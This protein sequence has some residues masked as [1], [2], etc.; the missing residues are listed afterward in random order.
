[1]LVAIQT[2]PDCGA[3]VHSRQELDMNTITL[4]HRPVDG[5]AVRCAKSSGDRD[6][7]PILTS[8]C[9]ESLYAFESTWSVL[10]EHVNLVAIDL[11]GLGGSQRL[12]SFVVAPQ[13]TCAGGQQRWYSYAR[14][15]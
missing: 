7:T 4:D 8:P 9:P 13:A 12:P 3:S 1:M 5:V 2:S 14:P 15:A 11:P 6:E 10:S